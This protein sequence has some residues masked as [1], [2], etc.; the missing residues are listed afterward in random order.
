ME[1]INKNSIV[2]KLSVAYEI[3]CQEMKIL[4]LAAIISGDG[5]SLVRNYFDD[6]SFSPTNSVSRLTEEEN[7]AI[8]S[9]VMELY[10]RYGVYQPEIMIEEEV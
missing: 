7:S 10:E 4:S 5:I 8:L 6:G 3:R 2:G 1:T 9:D